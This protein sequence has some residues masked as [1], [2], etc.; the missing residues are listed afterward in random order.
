MLEGFT[1]MPHDLQRDIVPFNQPTAALPS[2]VFYAA[3]MMWLWR[4][5]RAHE[6]PQPLKDERQECQHHQEPYHRDDRRLGVPLSEPVK[7]CCDEG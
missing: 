1:L 7:P 2:A 5:C 3:C 6:H 4:C